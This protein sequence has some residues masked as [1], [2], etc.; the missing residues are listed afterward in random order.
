MRK[1]IIALCL[2]ICYSFLSTPLFAFPDTERI[3]ISGA[4]PPFN[5]G[6]TNTITGFALRDDETLI[7]SYGEVLSLVDLAYYDLSQSQPPPLTVDAKTDGRIAAIAYSKDHDRIYATQEDGDLLIFDMARITEDPRSFK[8]AEGH[9]LGQIALDNNGRNAYVIDTTNHTVLVFN[10]TALTVDNII[11]LNIP[12]I[13]SFAINDAVHVAATDEIYFLTDKGVVFYLPAGGLAATQITLDNT[14]VA[15][16]S[17]AFPT[18]DGAN[19]Y[20]TNETDNLL[21]RISTA[22]HAIVNDSIDLAENP[23]PSS[24]VITKVNRPKGGT[25]NAEYGYIAGSK[26][27]SV[28]N[29]ADDGILDMGTDPVI[30]REPIPMSAVPHRL[31]ATTVDDGYVYAA[32]ATQ[33]V[34]VLTANPWVTISSLTYPGG[35]DSMGVHESFTLAFQAD[36]AGTA[37]LHSGGDVY[38]SGIALVDSSSASSWP[39]DNPDTDVSVTINYDDNKDSFIE[40]A[41]SIFVFVTKDTNDKGRIAAAVNVDTPPPIVTMRSAGFGEARIYV[42]FD[43]IDVADMNH[44]NVYVDTNPDAVM[45]KTEVAATVAQASSGSTQ[46][47]QVGDLENG[48]AHFIAMEAVDNAGNISES[49]TNTFA[50]GSVAYAIPQTTAGPV[51]LSGEKGC[52]VVPVISNPLTLSRKASAD[53]L[54]KMTSMVIALFVPVI[55]FLIARRNVKST[56]TILISIIFFGS[57]FCISFETHAR[58]PSPQWWSAEIKTGFWMPSSNNVNHFFGNCCNLITRVQGGLLVH[59]RYGAEIG[60][61]FF[62]KNAT[63]SGTITGESSEDRFNFL[64]LPIE[65]NFVWRADYWS[66]DYVIPYMKAGLDYVFFRENLKGKIT[67]GVKYG[68]HV[69]GG[70]QLNMKMFDEGTILTLDDDFGI[71]DLFITLETQ[72]QFIDNFGSHGLDLSGPVFSA[73]LLFEF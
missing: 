26:G 45:T 66:W 19:I 3:G 49:R 35:G 27:I 25:G 44:Y 2:I 70:V 61:G 65:T 72:Y 40:G 6:F 73:G 9:K 60:A 63:A 57:M 21:V 18:V 69:A 67:K 41:N 54:V 34:G 11:A 7:V 29:T 36:E 28:L 8:I 16:L 47:A 51:E 37:T 15:N 43:R 48:I 32:N 68:F 1:S 4:S 62:M 53:S 55:L 56:R 71:N 23:S 31:V 38:G 12:T 59:G 10:L 52:T 5:F 14:Y 30:D 20:V 42:T 17:S 22:T 24:I 58:E 50:D 39:V 64:L 33:S 13:S 46:E